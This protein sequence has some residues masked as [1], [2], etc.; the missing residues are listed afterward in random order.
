M[1]GRV[2]IV[3]SSFDGRYS[4]SPR[5]LFEAL[6]DRPDIEHT[7]LAHPEHRETFPPGV[8]LAASRGTEA[9]K[10]LESADLVAASSHIEVEWDKP[11]GSTYLQ[12]WHG[13]PLKR[14]H[15]DVL[16]VPE[17][18]LAWLGEDVARWDVLL[19][20]NRVS[21]ARLRQAFRYEGAVLESG[22]PRNDALTSPRLEHLRRSTRAALGIGEERVI[23]YAPTFRDDEVFASETADLSVGLDAERFA[24]E[25]PDQTLLVRAHVMATGRL[26]VHASDRVTDVSMYPDVRDLYAAA[27]VLVTD[28]SSTMFD[29]AITGRPIVF[30]AYDLED[31][32]D[33]IRGFYFDL[34]EVAPGPIVRST[35]ELIDVLRGIEQLQVEYAAR[36]RAF[37]EEFTSLE[38]GHATERV[39]AHLGL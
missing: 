1:M 13:T 22:Y 14:V 34:A 9:R 8:E 36:Y 20:P 24:R 28:Y 2:R 19:S 21:T 23:L 17:G 6:R 32:A 30:L 35:G 10:V 7:W 39:L 31:F 4:D 18:R 37:R 29:F 12:T 5:A 26:P 11:A 15:H 3:W 33:T 27:D 38:D 16:I 25:L